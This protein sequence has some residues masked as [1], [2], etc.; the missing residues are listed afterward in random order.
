MGGSL[1]GRVF[2]AGFRKRDFGQE[3]QA[4]KFVI[5]GRR[6][7]YITQLLWSAGLVVAGLSSLI[8]GWELDLGGT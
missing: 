4:D 7:V 3:C 6:M 2:H 5:Y 8:V 1:C